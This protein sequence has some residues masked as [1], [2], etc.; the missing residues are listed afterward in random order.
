MRQPIKLL[1]TIFLI[2]SVSFVGCTTENNKPTPDHQTW[3]QLPALPNVFR[4]EASSFSIG[5][6]AY[7]GLGLGG[8]NILYRANATENN[9][10]WEFNAITNAWRR[11]A[12]F[13]GGKRSGATSFAING[14]GYIAFGYST[15]C[16]VNGGYCDFTFYNDIWEYTPTSNT[17][18]KVAD[19]KSIDKTRNAQVFVVNA[20]AYILTGFECIE[21]DPGTYSIQ[22]RTNCPIGLF[23]GTFSLNNKGYV[24]LGDPDTE[25]NKKVY[26]Y[27]PATDTWSQ[28]KDF[29]GQPRIVPASFSLN[30]YGYCGGGY[31]RGNPEQ[32]FKDFWQYNSTTDQWTQIEDYPSV[33]SV[34]L[35][36]MVVGSNVMVGSGYGYEKG[37]YLYD[38]TFWLFQPN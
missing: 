16:P 21:F 15:S 11:M 19:Y 10:F 14:R 33:G 26:E 25:Q 30:G 3:S 37:Q 29:P 24:F 36:S 28:K 20:K 38:N 35:K 12:D 34:Y 27:N 17:W 8:N 23:S 7:F 31:R 9:D 4:E 32:L 2:L 6:N 5:T 1:P 18:R 13:Q 22:K